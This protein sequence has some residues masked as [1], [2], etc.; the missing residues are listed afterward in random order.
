VSNGLVAV[1]GIDTD[2]DD[3]VEMGCLSLY[4]PTGNFIDQVLFSSDTSD[5]WLNSVVAISDSILLVVGGE[6]GAATTAPFVGAAALVS[7][8]RLEKRYNWAVESIPDR[9]FDN[10]VVDSSEPLTDQ[11]IFYVL[12]DG[13]S[14]QSETGTITVHRLSAAYPGLSPCTLEWSKEI[15]VTAGM[16]TYAGTGCNLRFFQGN[17]YL[18]GLADDPAKQPAPS[19]GGYWNSGIAASLTPA[20]D[21]RW[22]TSIALTGHSERFSAMAIGSDALYAVGQAASFFRSDNHFGYG[23]VTKIAL[24]TGEVLSNMTFGEDTYRSMF[25][26]PALS[27]NT[28]TCGGYTGYEVTG[29]GYVAWF[30]EIDVSNPPTPPL[31]SSDGTTRDGDGNSMVHKDNRGARSGP[32]F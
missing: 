27:G 11:I 9:F 15:I 22:L 26:C 18:V 17:L 7:P 16:G 32:A 31:V 21:L 14:S 25:Y 3:E 12:S 1:G 13:T 24:E 6:I 5:I 8:D 20:G 30:C 23:L 28:I 10:I 4:G 29:G 19:N 2:G